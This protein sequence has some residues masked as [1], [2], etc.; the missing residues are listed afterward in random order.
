MSSSRQVVNE[1]TFYAMMLLT[2][3][4]NVNGYVKCIHRKF[5][6]LDGNNNVQAAKY[7]YF[8]HAVDSSSLDLGQETATRGVL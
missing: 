5:D 4:D 8:L 1:A 6:G 7:T 2:S 3:F